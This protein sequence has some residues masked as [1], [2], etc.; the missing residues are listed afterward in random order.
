MQLQRTIGGYAMGRKEYENKEHLSS[1]D[2][3]KYHSRSA[4][5]KKEHQSEEKNTKDKFKN[6][7]T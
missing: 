5:Y 7:T 6:S 3:A 1:Y 4:Q 2:S